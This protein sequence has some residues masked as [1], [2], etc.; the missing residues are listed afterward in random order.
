MVSAILVVN[1]ATTFI[2]FLMTFLHVD[3]EYSS[4][5]EVADLDEESGALAM[6]SPSWVRTP[7][8]VVT[9]E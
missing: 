6:P 9:S 8:P 7:V 5:E 1:S 2:T 4:D 3:S